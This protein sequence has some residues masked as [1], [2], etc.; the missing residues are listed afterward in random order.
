MVDVTLSATAAPSRASFGPDAYPVLDA[1]R[2][3]PP[4]RLPP[5]LRRYYLRADLPERPSSAVLVLEMNGTYELPVIENR[6]IRART[7]KVAAAIVVSKARHT[8]SCSAELDSSDPLQKF[9]VEGRFEC[10]VND[11]LVLLQNG[12]RQAADQLRSYLYDLVNLRSELA[13]L[14][15]SELDSKL[16][17]LISEAQAEV[18]LKPPSIPG[19][20]VQR[21]YLTFVADRAYHDVR[22]GQLPAGEGQDA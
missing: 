11:P 17:K 2:L 6:G 4:R 7:N 20:S 12:C 10:F 21:S 19:M 9:L 3:P 8:V 15:V 22:R 5:F 13:R 1:K 14:H 16:S 18:E